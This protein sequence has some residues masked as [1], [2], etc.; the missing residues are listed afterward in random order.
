MAT[1]NQLVR[2]FEK[3]CGPQPSRQLT[4]SNLLN[5]ETGK[6]NRDVYEA[7]VRREAMHTFGSTAPRY[8]REAGKLYRCHV[9]DQTTAWR[10]ARG[11]LVAMTMVAPFDGGFGSA[12]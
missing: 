5:Q 4:V 2:E 9:E 11:L 7:L 1:I 3:V 12:F 10:Q 6:L 8:L